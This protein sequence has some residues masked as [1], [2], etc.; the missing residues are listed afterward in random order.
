MPPK[1]KASLKDLLLM[2]H[3]LKEETDVI[4]TMGENLLKQIED[5]ELTPIQED[6]QKKDELVEEF[7]L[8]G[9]GFR[10]LDDMKTIL[11]IRLQRKMIQTLDAASMGSRAKSMTLSR[12]K[13][14]RR[15]RRVKS[16]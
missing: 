15:T 16:I 11:M 2:A 1:A 12:S 5:I 10:R 13:S 3:K 7:E 4:A 6:T 14:S 9:Q 8:L